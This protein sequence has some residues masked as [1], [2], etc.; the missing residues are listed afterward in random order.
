MIGINQ[1]NEV[2]SYCKLSNVITWLFVDCPGIQLKGSNAETPQHFRVHHLE[3][4]TY[5]EQFQTSHRSMLKEYRRNKRMCDYGQ[6]MT[7]LKKF[8]NLNLDSSLTVSLITLSKK[9]FL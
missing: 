6:S 1:H 7:A 8:Q 5:T 4:Q 9:T 2:N 3:R